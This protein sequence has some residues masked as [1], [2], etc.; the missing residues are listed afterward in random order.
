MQRGHYSQKKDIV[1]GAGVGYGIYVHIM[2]CFL[3]VLLC[4]SSVR[5]FIL[6]KFEI[7]FISEFMIFKNVHLLSINTQD[8]VN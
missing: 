1:L 2:K 3:V 8:C 6:L 5:T 7:S 4:I